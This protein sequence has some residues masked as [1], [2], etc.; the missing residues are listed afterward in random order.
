MP[1]YGA[2]QNKYISIY[3]G[4]SADILNKIENSQIYFQFLEI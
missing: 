1:Y 2:S 4:C 3:Y